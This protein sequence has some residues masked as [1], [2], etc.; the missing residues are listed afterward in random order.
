[1]ATADDGE[2][3]GARVGQT[4]R[5]LLLWIGAA[6]LGA[7][8]CTALANLALGGGWSEDDVRGVLALG[9]G[10]LIFTLGGSAFLVLVFAWMER[11]SM[12]PMARYGTLILV[13]AAAGA[14]VMLPF[15]T[16]AS[17]AAGLAYGVATAMAW[18]ALHRIL[19]GTR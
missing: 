18:A 2:R 14:A 7:F 15:G 17:S 9:L 19:F 13:G 16:P 4:I 8:G 10:T 5:G 11:W 3:R 1:M 12:P 6:V